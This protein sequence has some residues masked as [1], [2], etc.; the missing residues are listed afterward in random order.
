MAG[1]TC[2]QADEA[3]RLE[4]GQLLL[5]GGNRRQPGPAFEILV[6]FAPDARRGFGSGSPAPLLPDGRPRRM[7]STALPLPGTTAAEVGLTGAVPKLVDNA[8]AAR[9]DPQ[10][11]QRAQSEVVLQVLHPVT[12]R[13]SAVPQTLA[14]CSVAARGVRE[15]A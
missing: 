6:V 11:V 12:H 15:S 2:A 14:H 4:R 5:E 8:P 3:R 10:P 13:R 1:A 9:P 7:A